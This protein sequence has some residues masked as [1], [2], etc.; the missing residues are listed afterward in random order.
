MISA[1]NLHIEDETK[2][3]APLMHLRE[4]LLAQVHEQQAAQQKLLSDLS[5][6]QEDPARRAA[7][8]SDVLREAIDKLHEKG[9]SLAE[10]L[11]PDILKGVKRTFETEPDVMAG[12]LYPVLGPAVRKLVASL[13]DT[14]SANKGAPYQ[15]EQLLLI[16]TESSIVLSQVVAEE[17][18]AHD[19]DI[20][21]GMLDAIRQFVQ[22]A[23]AVNNFDGMNTLSIGDITVWVEW[24]PKAV[25]AVVIRGIAADLDRQAFVELLERIHADYRVELNQFDGDSAL[26]EPVG[27]ILESCLLAQVQRKTP[28]WGRH[29]LNSII[30]ATTI[31]SVSIMFVAN[32]REAKWTSIKNEL[33]STP[34]LVVLNTERGWLTSRIQILKD[35]LARSPRLVLLLAGID[36]TDL[37]LESH[38]FQSA[39]SEIIRRRTETAGAAT[40]DVGDTDLSTSALSTVGN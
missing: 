30:L 17:R 10:A 32:G 27:K 2:A 25:L 3:D 28:W 34:G 18:A 38:A 14:S 19:A 12:A 39:D 13:F 36:P 6:R 40:D 5:I 1:Q 21:S 15:I 8:V 23:F 7:D 9:I 16:H 11:E 29:R 33:S 20:V 31:L 26:F 22:E 35:P 24:G 37:I 4:L